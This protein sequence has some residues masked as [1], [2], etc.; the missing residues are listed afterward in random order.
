MI[1]MDVADAFRWQAQVCAELGSVMYGDMLTRIADELAADDS[2]HRRALAEVLR[3]HEHDS[4]PSALALRLAGAVHRQVLQGEAPDLAACY[5]SVGGSWDLET[6]W[7]RFL[8]TLR[9]RG[10]AIRALL[11]QPPQTNEVGRSAALMGG[12]LHVAARH[13]APIRLFEIG[14]SGGLNLCVDHFRYLRADGSGW[15]SPDSE[16]VLDPGWQGAALPE[17]EPRIIERMGSDRNPVDV[18]T[19]DGRMTL[20][21]YVWPDQIARLARLRGAFEVAARVPIE[22]RRTD[23]VTAVTRI[24]L[25]AGTTTVL[26]HSVLWQY[27]GDDD[28]HAVQAR[29]ADLAGQ[30]TGEQP[31]VH[32]TLE[33]GRRTEHDQREFLVVLEDWPGGG[34]RALGT[35]APHGVPV[36]W[37]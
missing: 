21:S 24:E 22:I 5:P 8:A 29:I 26:W 2:A 4:G 37:E 34:R 23:A 14:S 3:G 31:F 12:L 32:L 35:A 7:P 10:D 6:A 19:D 1:G 28:Q 13:K 30:A 25:R 33:P 11:D 36:T 18:G 27:L 17:A 9:A 16:V 20:L 15:G